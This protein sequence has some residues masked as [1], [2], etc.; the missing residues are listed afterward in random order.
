MTVVTHYEVAF[1]FELDRSIIQTFNFRICIRFDNQFTVT[2]KLAL[3]NLD[4]ITR[5]A[6]DTFY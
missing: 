6:Y 1:R 5:Y 3:P 2:V 4:R